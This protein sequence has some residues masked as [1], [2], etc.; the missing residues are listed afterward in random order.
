VSYKVSSRTRL[1]VLRGSVPESVGVLG[2]GHGGV[3]GVAAVDRLL[4]VGVN[5]ARVV[6]H[7]HLSQARQALQLVL[8]EDVA[9]LVV[10]QI[11]AVVPRLP[12]QARQQRTGLARRQRTA[13]GQP[14]GELRN[15]HTRAHTHTRAAEDRRQR[16]ILQKTM[17]RTE[18]EGDRLK[19]Q[20][21]GRKV[22]ERG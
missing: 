2:R 22:D 9:V 18:G 3:G 20:L 13:T 11:A 7:A 19:A 17:G 14:S 1:A 6:A 15:T 12:E 5:L 10:G 16:K 21:Q 8:V 4:E